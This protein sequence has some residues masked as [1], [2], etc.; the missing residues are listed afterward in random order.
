VTPRR[1][2]HGLVPQHVADLI[3]GW[4]IQIMI[5]RPASVEGTKPTFLREEKQLKQDLSI[6]F[7]SSQTADALLPQK[8]FGTLNWLAP[9]VGLE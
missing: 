9:V 1:K 6:L 2:T 7:F 3:Q 8:P 4:Y 5:C